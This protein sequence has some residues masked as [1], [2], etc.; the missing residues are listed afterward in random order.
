MK[1]VFEKLTES[2]EEG[3]AVKVIRGAGFQCP[4]HFHPECELTL[5]LQS[6]GYRMVGDDITPLEPGD[7]VLVGANL[8]HIW[9]NDEHIP[10]KKQPVHCVLVQFEA[11]FLGPALL[12]LPAL[13]PIRRLIKRA[14]LGVRVTG[15]TRQHAA[16]LMLQL[17][18]LRGMGRI[19]TFLKIL[20]LLAHSR[21]CRTIASP[22]FD[23][24]SSPWSADDQLRL[25]RVCQFINERLDQPIRLREAARL[26]HL[27]EGAF[28][29]FFRR[30]LRRTFPEFINELRIGRACRL[31]AETEMPV[32]EIAAACGY[33]NLSN[34]N[35]QFLRFKNIA[36]RRFRRRIQ[37]IPPTAGGGDGARVRKVSK[38][39]V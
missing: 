28:S 31:L 9:Q 32:T 14:S 25:S 20:D 23:P 15:R 18:K 26:A 22:G 36:P 35:R 34:F 24:Q 30:H 6:G 5:V 17:V 16:A 1:L 19:I 12:D 11:Q 3:F 29:R 13:L 33:T 8:P 39:V 10:G 4:L 2:P 7:L 37:P 38:V 27:S 21:E